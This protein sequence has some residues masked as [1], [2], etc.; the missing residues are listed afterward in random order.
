M[1]R[2]I[3][4]VILF[5]AV[6]GGYV[7]VTQSRA[8]AGPELK[9]IAAVVDSVRDASFPHLKGAEITLHEMHSDYVYLETR[10]TIPSFL[11]ERRLRYMVTFNPAA[12]ARG[13][14]P[15]GLRAIV[16]HELAHADYFYSHSRMGLLSLIQLLSA[17]F[18][19]QFE[20]AADLEAISLGY[21][22]GLQLYRTWLYQNVPANRMPE[23]K[24]NYFSPEE[25]DAILRAVREDPH[26]MQTFARCVPRDIMEIQREA[27]NPSGSCDH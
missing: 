11:F 21:G 10:F 1:R 18:T 26:V 19:V 9:D 17:R 13:V 7:A 24:A 3:L 15:D 8:D 25:I 12:L 4:I 6:A 22:P 2:L 5:A 27:R 16:A 20:R 14:P 23:K